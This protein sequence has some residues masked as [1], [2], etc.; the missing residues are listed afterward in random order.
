MAQPLWKIHLKE[1]NRWVAKENDSA[2]KFVLRRIQE[3]IQASVA[4]ALTTGYPYQWTDIWYD[5]MIA[6]MV[7]VTTNE[8]KWMRETAHFAR[9]LKSPE[10]KENKVTLVNNF[11][12]WL[13]LATYRWNYVRDKNSRGEHRKMKSGAPVSLEQFWRDIVLATYQILTYLKSNVPPLDELSKWIFIDDNYPRSHPFN[14]LFDYNGW[15]RWEFS[16]IFECISF[17]IFCRM[18][19]MGY[20]RWEL[21]S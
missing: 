7:H 10:H 8:L 6:F 9:V 18:I 3:K 14:R 17:M 20:E 21:S 15:Y 12:S 4:E 11:H 13:P 2:G 5:E 19:K 1:K 16:N